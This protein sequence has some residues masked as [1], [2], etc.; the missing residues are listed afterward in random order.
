MEPT[1]VSK[2]LF[3]RPCRLGICV[4]VLQHPKGRFYQ[5]EPPRFPKATASNVVDE[6]H[7][8]VELGMLDV[9]EP[10]DSRRIYYVRTDSALWDVVA[11]A[12]RALNLPGAAPQ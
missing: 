4:W 7:R 1:H 3:G 10:D 2:L 6:L 11:A 5:S 12:A 9:E 8:L